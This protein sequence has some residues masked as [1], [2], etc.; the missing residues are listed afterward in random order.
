MEGLGALC[1][2]IGVD[3][4][5]DVRLL[6]FCWRLN[7]KAPGAIARDEWIEGLT[8]MGLDSEEKIQASFPQYDPG[9]LEHKTFREFFKVR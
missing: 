9:F 8:P 1:E 7:A 6:V 2:A 3:P 4:E 5:A